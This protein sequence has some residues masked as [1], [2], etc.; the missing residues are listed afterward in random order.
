M[1]VGL[2]EDMVRNGVITRSTG[3][4]VLVGGRYVMA[5][6]PD[7]ALGRARGCTAPST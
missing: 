3:Y 2:Y 5:T 4:P 1:W 6:T 7:P